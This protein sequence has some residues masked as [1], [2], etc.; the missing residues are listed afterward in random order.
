LEPKLNRVKEELRKDIKINKLEEDILKD[1]KFSSEPYLSEAFKPDNELE[2]LFLAQHYGVSTR[3]LD[4]TENP[5]IALWFAFEEVNDNEKDRRIWYISFDKNLVY[6]LKKDFPIETDEIFI[7]RPPLK[8]RRIISQGSW[9]TRHPNKDE[10]N[11]LNLSNDL[12]K[13]NYSLDSYTFKDSVR[14]EVLSFLKIININQ[15]SVYQDLASVSKYVLSQY[16]NIFTESI[17]LS[18]KDSGN[19]E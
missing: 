13:K 6:D 4:W 12:I 3:L 10:N 7:L 19:K 8:T 15:G 2:W 14:N 17:S 16:S 11:L 9:F 1:F 5:L 18:C